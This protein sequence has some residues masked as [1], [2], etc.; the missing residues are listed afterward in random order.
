MNEHDEEVLLYFIKEI[1]YLQIIT[2]KWS[3]AL[4]QC[5]VGKNRFEI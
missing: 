4:N 1:V 5:F 3:L 2:A